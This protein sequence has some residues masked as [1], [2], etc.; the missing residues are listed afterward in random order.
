MTI[1]TGSRINF[2]M[3]STFISISIT[4]FS[5]YFQIPLGFEKL[6]QLKH[7]VKQLY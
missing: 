6:K 5:G 7:Q 4:T 1:L 2:L 3:T